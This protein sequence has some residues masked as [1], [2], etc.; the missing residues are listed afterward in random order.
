[1]QL[2]PLPAAERGHHRL[3]TRRERAD[4]A[5]GVDVAQLRLAGQGVAL[6]HTAVG[7]AVAQ[8]VLGAGDQVLAIEKGAA[9]GRPLQA[10]DH[11]RGVGADDLGILGVALIGPSPAAVAGHGEG[12]SEVPVLP[13]H[14]HLARGHPAQ[15]THQ[16]GVVG[17]AQAD[18]VR[19]QRGADHVVVTVHRVQA[20]DDRDRHAALGGVHRR[21]PEGVGK[22]QPIRRRRA[23]L[24]AG[25]AAAAVEDRAE[26]VGLDLRRRH[27]VDLGLDDLADLVL[28]R[29]CCEELRDRPL[30]L[31]I[32]RHRARHLR[33]ARGIDRGGPGGRQTG[34]VDQAVRQDQPGDEDK[35]RLAELSDPHSCHSP[36]SRIAARSAATPSGRP[37]SGQE[38]RAATRR[39]QPEWTV[40]VGE[41][42]VLR[43]SASPPAAPGGDPARRW[44]VRRW[45]A[46]RRWRPPCSPSHAARRAP[47][48]RRSSGRSTDR[49]RWS[50]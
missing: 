36:V 32:R 9:V 42:N 3:H 37:R 50:G 28:D 43:S 22:G 49:R 31:G 8:E 16:I 2:G 24:V 25:P 27:V 48:P 18:V 20:P 15:L 11:G 6:V 12:R 10:L 13:G 19:Q 33:P 7:A 1:M 23:L 35:H 41:A 47:H 40:K 34:R 30:D 5:G 14:R 39:P 17:G 38:K 45:P 4:V 26:A 29:H 46:A 44:P 21:F